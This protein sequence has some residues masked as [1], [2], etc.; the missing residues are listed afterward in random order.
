[1][2][3]SLSTIFF[4]GQEDTLQAILNALKE[5][6]VRGILTTG[7]VA[8]GALK[9]PANV[10][11]H[12][13]LPNDEIMPKASLVV[14]HGGHSTTMRALAHGLTL[15]ILPM[16]SI[17]DKAIIGKAVAGAGAGLVLPKTASMDESRH[18]VEA[19]LQNPSYNQAAEAI[20]K[21]LHACDGAIA[22]ADEIEAVLRSGKR[23]AIS[24]A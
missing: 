18:A 4:E 2:L 24:A 23:S 7:T 13:Y 6:Q 1:V 21:R 3:I 9:A 20:G 19:L 11:V 15:L 8:P 12:E 5:L 16:H 14:G 10:E 17:L 22:A